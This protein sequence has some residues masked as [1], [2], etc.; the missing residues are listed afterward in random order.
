MNA[1][2]FL[3]DFIQKNL[4]YAQEYGNTL[5]GF[6]T[7]QGLNSQP[8]GGTGLYG[9]EPDGSPRSMGEAL[10]FIGSQ[11]QKRNAAIDALRRRY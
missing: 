10:D 4:P 3:S 5:L 11:S 2:Q 1:T 8:L 9:Y 7:P 6:F